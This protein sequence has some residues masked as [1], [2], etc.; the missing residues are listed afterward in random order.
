MKPV[1]GFVAAQNPKVLPDRHIVNTPYINAV[2]V[3]GGTPVLIPVDRNP[4][5]AEEYISMLDGL[6][7]PGGEDV[8]PS[9]YG[10]APIW[11]VTYMNEDKDRMELALIRLAVER[12]IP[13]FGICRGIQLLN[14]CFG[15]TL[16]QDLP[17]QVAGSVCH[18]Q[19]MAIRSQLTHPVELESGS[20][21]RTLLGSEPLYVNS[22]HHQA[23]KDL[24]P[25]FIVTARSPDGVIEAVEDPERNIYA[26]QWH[27]EELVTRYPRF[28]PL[29]A[30]LVKLAA[31]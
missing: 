15:G 2:I 9:L 18:L 17:F 21:M 5:R 14:V 20:L 23:L 30:H 11:Q 28:R 31:Q 19:D 8:T 22:Y 24:A 26:V 10:Q 4:D 6:L 13:V 1:I 25:N 7:I 27:P 12:R 3:A 16:Y 29:F